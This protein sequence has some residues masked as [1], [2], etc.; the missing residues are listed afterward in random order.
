MGETTWD[1]LKS[2]QMATKLD[3]KE[4]MGLTDQDPWAKQSFKINPSQVLE[5]L[6]ISLI[7]VTG[8]NN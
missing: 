4:L 2:T 6:L 5:K 3:Y 7:S 1:I 8:V